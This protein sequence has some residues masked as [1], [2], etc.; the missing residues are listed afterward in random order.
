MQTLDLSRRRLSMQ[1]C[2]MLATLL[3]RKPARLLKHSHALNDS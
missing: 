1:F 2:L 3:G